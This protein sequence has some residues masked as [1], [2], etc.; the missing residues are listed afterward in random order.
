MQP[1]KLQRSDGAPS[2]SDR[3]FAELI[4]QK[5]RLQQ[6]EAEYAQKI[7]KLKEAQAL[8]NKGLP[9]DL[10]P[11]PPARAATPPDARAP[12][13]PPSPI[14]PL[15]QPSL[16]DLT[17]DKLT[18]DSEDA[19]A[20]PEDHESESASAAARRSRRT[21]LLLCNSSFTKPNLELLTS[22]PIKDASAGKPAKS[23]GSPKPAE[24]S[25]GLD[26]EALRQSYQQQEQLGEL[27]LAEL[28]RVGDGV[29][30]PPAGKVSSIPAGS[31]SVWSSSEKQLLHFMTV[32]LWL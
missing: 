30:E 19:A 25:A 3:H 8:R 6:L 24:A 9:A 31:A 20:E 11:E 1:T 23:C 21:S 13:P 4:A 16:H 29:D 28:R 27:L 17:Q 10:P 5:Q 22:T 12:L 2:R 7:Q 14:C 26:V 15:P 32:C 18:L